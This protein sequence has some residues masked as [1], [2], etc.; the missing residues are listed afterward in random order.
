MFDVSL[1]QL[2]DVSHTFDIDLRLRKQATK[3]NVA[4]CNELE[5]GK[6]SIAETQ[7]SRNSRHI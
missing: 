3:K 1:E 6:E 5:K 7:G 2:C 4:I